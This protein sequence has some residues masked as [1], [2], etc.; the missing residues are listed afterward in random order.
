[1]VGRLFV[2]GSHGVWTYL[3]VVESFGGRT[4]FGVG[5]TFP[6]YFGGS[7]CKVGF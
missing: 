3:F 5:R 7:S 1:M 4:W 2:V 6:L